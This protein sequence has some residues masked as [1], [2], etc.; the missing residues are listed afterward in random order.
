MKKIL[1]ITIAFLGILSGCTDLSND[2]YDRILASDFPENDAQAQMSL[3]PVYQPLKD[4]VDGGCYWFAQELTGDDVV[5]PT[6]ENDWDDGGKWRDLHKHTWNNQSETVNS[7]WSRYFIGIGE[8]N[9]LIDASQEAAD[10]GS[11]IAKQIIV[12]C[13][14]MRD[15]YYWN[16]IDTYGDVPYVT[17]YTNADPAP[18]VEKRDVIWRAIVEELESVYA[19]VPVE[20][21]KY[22]VTRGMVF[23]LLAKLY[24]NAEVYTGTAQWAKADMYLDSVI[25]LGQYSLEA[26][27][28]AP[29]VTNNENSTENIFTIG[30]DED[31]YQGFNLHMRTLN[32]NNQETFNMTQQPWNGFAA[33]ED[34]YNSFDNADLRKKMFLVGM[35]YSASGQPLFDATANDTVV[36]TANIPALKMDASYTPQQVRMSGARFVKF[37]VKMGASGNLSNDFPLFRYADVI[38]MKAE[39]QVRLNGAGAGDTYIN[40]IRNRAGLTSLSGATLD[41]ILDERAKEFVWEAQRRMDLIRFGEFTKSWWEKDTDDSQDRTTFPIPQWAIDANPNLAN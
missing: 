17:S 11:E 12:S 23:T 6:R 9:K 36:L 39:T 14:V 10:A 33:M 28:L 40:Q 2:Y 38:M 7:M 32:Y 30:Y 22:A 26:D 4:Y 13:K 34:F 19:D 37:E 27:P 35:Q 5:C 16:A 24:L 3:A 25:A 1:I 21:S 31:T 41:D 18:K 29:F 15:F 8:A 20:G